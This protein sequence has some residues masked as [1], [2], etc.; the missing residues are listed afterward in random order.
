MKT[1]RFISET[2]FP[3]SAFQVN[4]GS[5]YGFKPII[6][7]VPIC[8][9]HI[10]H[11]DRSRYIDLQVTFHFEAGNTSEALHKVVTKYRD[12]VYFGGVK[13]CVSFSADFAEALGLRI[14]PRPNFSPSHFVKNLARLN[15]R[16][17]APGL[18]P[19]S[20]D[21]PGELC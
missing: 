20:G 2:G 3:H 8:S 4:G 10:D 16:A 15:G 12:A 1:V 13:D 7:K 19:K 21:A 6:P 5:W 9:G 14:P 17:Y 18:I 11:S